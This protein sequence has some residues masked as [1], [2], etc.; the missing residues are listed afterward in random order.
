MNRFFMARIGLRFLIEHHITSGIA[1]TGVAS[2]TTAPPAARA[3]S[4]AEGADGGIVSGIIESQCRPLTVAEWAAEDARHLCMH[5]FGMSPNV[6][7]HGDPDVSFTYV[8][9][10]LQYILTELLKNALRATVEAHTDD[11]GEL[12]HGHGSAEENRP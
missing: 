9:G 6:V 2:G 7:L 4:M 11:E 1:A 12:L 8:P 3:S 10:H 5:H